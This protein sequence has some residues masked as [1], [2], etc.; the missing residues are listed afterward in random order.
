MLIIPLPAGIVI[1]F[2]FAF[3]VAIII[4]FFYIIHLKEFYKS[5]LS[6][7]KNNYNICLQ[8]ITENNNKLIKYNQSLKIRNKLLKTKLIFKNK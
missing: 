4:T 6:F 1:S 7:Q 3:V 8:S 5:L 2:L